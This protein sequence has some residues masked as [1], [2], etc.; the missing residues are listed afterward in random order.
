M[1]AREPEGHAATP[2]T[3][4][5]LIDPDTMTVLWATGSPGETAAGALSIEEAVP[6]AGPLGVA[7]AVRD[8]ASTGAPRYLQADLVSTGK[9]A[10]AM[11]VSLHRLPDGNVLALAEHTWVPSGAA[12]APP[13]SPRHPRRR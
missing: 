7:E 5:A 4:A 3:K 8:V 13:A 10:M 12:P 6:M 2:H 1:S 11:L 9:G